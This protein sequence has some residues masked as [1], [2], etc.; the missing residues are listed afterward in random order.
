[1]YKLLGIYKQK[2]SIC[3]IIYSMCL[4][5]YL[6]CDK[7]FIRLLSANCKFKIQCKLLLQLLQCRLVN[8]LK[9]CLSKVY[10]RSKQVSY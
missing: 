9:H 2:E 3:K 5:Y 1:M 10:L 7:G 4:L 6:E 8:L